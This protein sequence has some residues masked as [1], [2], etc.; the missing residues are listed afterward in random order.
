MREVTVS[1]QFRNTIVMPLPAKMPTPGQSP[2]SR[3]QELVI[4]LSWLFTI[5]PS[6]HPV[7]LPAAADTLTHLRIAAVLAS[8]SRR[9]WQR[10]QVITTHSQTLLLR[11]K[12]FEADFEVRSCRLILPPSS[13]PKKPLY[14]KEAFRNIPL[15]F[16]QTFRSSLQMMCTGFYNVQCHLINVS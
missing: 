12:S 6:L 7:Y 9:Q 14:Q 16:S 3:L 13:P 15:K 10:M 8:V 11:L 4:G 2:I 5:A 1:S